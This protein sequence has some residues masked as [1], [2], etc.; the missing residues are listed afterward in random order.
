VTGSVAMKCWETWESLRTAVKV[1]SPAVNMT[2]VKTVSR[3]VGGVLL[4]GISEQAQWLKN[5]L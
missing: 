2:G 4:Q 5:G 3:P 1:W